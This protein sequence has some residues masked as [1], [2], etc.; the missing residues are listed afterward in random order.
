MGLRGLLAC[1]TPLL[2]VIL[3]FVF[4]VEAIPCFIIGILWLMVF[5]YKGN[6]SKYISMVT[7]S[8]YNGIRDLCAASDIDDGNRYDTE[9]GQRISD[10]DRAAFHAGDNAGYVDWFTD[11]LLCSQPLS[12]YRGP[13]NVLGL[14]ACL[15]T[16][17]LNV[18]NFPAVV[19]AAVFYCTFRW[20]AQACPTA[21]Q[22]VWTSNFVKCEPVTLTNKVFIPNWIE[23][24]VSV[25]LTG[26]AYGLIA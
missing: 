18:G 17:I 19:L 15:A 5:T 24:A 20:P 12:L 11:I 8:C 14:G 2:I 6:W 7:E 9:R 22:V 10:T 3:T 25:I 4:K 23:T 13:F 26:L 1:M 16:C 21:T